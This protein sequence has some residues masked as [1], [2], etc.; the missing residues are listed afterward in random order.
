MKKW[1]AKDQQLEL[2]RKTSSELGFEDLDDEK[3]DDPKQLLYFMNSTD[4]EGSQYERSVK[5]FM[6]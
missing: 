2:A 6:K 5:Y 1:R 4:I 3:L